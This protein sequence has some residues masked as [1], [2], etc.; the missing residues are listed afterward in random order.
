L[1][2]DG[3]VL[4]QY[5]EGETRGDKVKL[6]RLIIVLGLLAALLLSATPAYADTLDP[7]ST[8]TVDEINIYRNS[9]ESGDMVIII[10]A[11]I[12]YA[13]P[14]DTTEPETFIWRLIDTD[15]T[16]ELASTIGY[17]YNDDGYGYNV[18][19]MYLSAS[20]VSALPIIWGTSY[21]IRLSGNPAVFDTAPVYN[22][23]INASN[24]SSLTT[25]ADV[26]AG[27]AARI[28]TLAADLDTKWG[29]TTYS[30]LT[31]NETATVLS[32]YGEA[33]FRGAIF[34]L[35]SMAPAAFSVI[36]RVLNV[37]AR[38][39]SD[40]YTTNL[41]NQWSGT[42][43]ETGQEA[44]KALFGTTYDLL[45]IIMLLVMCG[46]LVVGNLSLTGDHWNGLVDVS[47]LG[48]IGARLGMYDLAFLMLIA[49]MAWIYISAKIWFGMIK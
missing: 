15:N 17:A 7:D 40:N 49:A 1:G 9:I 16:T 46:W 36:I 19:S 20:T 38:T 18:Y 8:P 23:I 34:G 44:G 32:I 13:T 21:T 28:L 30:L 26:Q 29:L 11:N 41:T 2:G 35:Q 14:P 25:Q 37:E 22:F 4:P 12:P 27:I 5:A 42:W 48:I 43:I 10:Y 45:S 47:V 39:W 24:Y 31:Q 3:T 6:F 33:F